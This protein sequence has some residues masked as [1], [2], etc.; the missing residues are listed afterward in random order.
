MAGP[1]FDEKDAVVTR[2][3]QEKLQRWIDAYLDDRL[4]EAQKAEFQRFLEK[5]AAVR[6]ELDLQSE[7]DNS[8]KRLFSPPDGQTLD[9]DQLVARSDEMTKTTRRSKGWL[10][11]RAVVAAASL[12]IA[13]GGGGWYAWSLLTP[14]VQEFKPRFPKLTLAQAYQKFAQ[15]NFKADWACEDEKEFACTFDYRLGKGLA[16]AQA[17]AGVEVLGLSY[18][19]TI[20]QNSILLTAKADGKGIIVFVDRVTADRGQTV[21]PASGLKLHKRKLDHLMLYEVSRLDKPRVLDLL[22]EMNTP[23]EWKKDFRPRS[24]GG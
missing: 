24:F 18:A 9:I 17:P 19:N 21:D 11:P 6:S 23:K 4:N 5:N 16:L 20:T 8:L 22:K 10:R 7:I 1:Y 13:L 15:N 12:L 3:D 14:P 2:K